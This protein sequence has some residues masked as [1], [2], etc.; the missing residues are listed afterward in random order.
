[1]AL[2]AP[3]FAPCV[4]SASFAAMSS[5]D[6]LPTIFHSIIVGLIV[7]IVFILCRGVFNGFGGKLCV[8]AFFSVLIVFLT[9]KT[10]VGGVEIPN[11]I[12]GLAMILSCKFGSIVTYFLSS[13][14]KLGPVLAL[15]L[16]TLGGGIFFPAIFPSIG[17]SLASCLTAGSYAGADMLPRHIFNEPKT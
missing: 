4:Y 12:Q 13:K 16:V 5:L 10:E 7:G 11:L 9:I 15:S 2:I 6:I 1:M 17:G 8:V 3:K 14:M